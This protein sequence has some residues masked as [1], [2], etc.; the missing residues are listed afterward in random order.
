MA[1]ADE[2]ERGQHSVAYT[3]SWLDVYLACF[4]RVH[5]L[6]ETY[7]TLRSSMTDYQA[8]ADIETVLYLKDQSARGNWN[9]V[10]V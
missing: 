5:N 6:S 8:N 10:V 2:E 3:W 4:D 9:G 1:H 7:S